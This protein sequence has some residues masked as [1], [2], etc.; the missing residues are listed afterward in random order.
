MSQ[1][2]QNFRGGKLMDVVDLL[3]IALEDPSEYLKRRLN[4]LK[5]DP[6]QLRAEVLSLKITSFNDAN[7]PFR[8]DAP[9]EADD[10]LDRGQLALF[11]A[12]RLHLIWCQMN[13][14]P[15]APKASARPTNDGV[16][17]GW[18]P[19]ASSRRRNTAHPERSA[20]PDTFVVHIGAPWGGGKTSFAN[21]VARALN[22]HGET[23]NG[24]HFLRSV[25]PA[26]ASPEELQKFNLD[27]IFFLRPDTDLAR[28]EAE[29]KR[30]PKE[31]R[32]PWIAAYYNAWRDQYVQP[33]WWHIF[34]TILAS[35]E[36]ALWADILPFGFQ[37]L[38]RLIKIKLVELRYK[39]FNA[40]MRNQLNL[41]L[42]SL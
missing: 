5:I 7:F 28:T 3:A 4:I 35:V 2:V 13:G 9:S 21:F 33:P 8:D 29:R 34:Q 22:P 17:I 24:R 27:E 40:K 42:L 6:D 41:I 10:A 19:T 37:S 12:R 14:C 38:A 32:K 20:G 23:L 1:G 26:G 15:P 39:L 11:L 36:N 25:A 16:R 18:W 31:A 30:W